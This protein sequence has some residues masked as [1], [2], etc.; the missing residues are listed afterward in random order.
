MAD[1]SLKSEKEL[2]KGFSMTVP[3][4]AA[5]AILGLLLVVLLG[6]WLV[7]GRTGPSS[8]ST[9]QADPTGTTAPTPESQPAIPPL[10]AAAPTETE[11]AT[12]AL[13]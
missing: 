5:I 13:G 7:V 12:F 3:F 2:W 8:D 10:D 6:A 4:K 1:K 9:R 11:T